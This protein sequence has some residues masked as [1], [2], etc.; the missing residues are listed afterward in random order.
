MLSMVASSAAFAKTDVQ[1]TLQQLKT[2]EENAK[3]NHK[4][5][6]ANATISSKNIEEVNGA[7]KAIRTQRQQLTSNA[8][9]LDKNRGM[10]DKMKA[11]LQEYR[12]D[13]SDQMAKEDAQI[14]QMKKVLEVLEANKAKREQNLTSYDQK[15]AEV[16]QEKKDW[17]SQKG[18]FGTLQAEL[19]KKEKT[20]LA[21]RERWITKKN[22]YKSE[23]DR[24][25][26]E[27]KV[28]EE[29]R[30]KFDKLKD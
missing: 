18:V 5:Y 12:K 1:G 20:A 28:A 16:E 2:N 25:G 27:A 10:L 24:W 26:K 22:G 17:D 14:A 13:E 19:D 23:A 9:N 21:E 15:I 6:E 8:Q 29:T 3:S 4:Q 11:K 7:L 30:V